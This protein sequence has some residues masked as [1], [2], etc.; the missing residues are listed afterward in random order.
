[1]KIAVFGGTGQTGRQFVEQALEA[2]HTLKVLARNPQK[3]SINHPH[4]EVIEG[5][6]TVLDDV[7]KV[8]DGQ[9]VVV[10]TIGGDGLDDAT[11]RTLG[12]GHII[13]S[14][15][16]S[17]VHQLIVCS[18]LGIGGSKKHLGMMG[19]AVL[20]TLLKK[21]KMDHEG[22]ESLVQSSDLKWVIIRPPRLNDGQHTG[23]YKI[24]HEDESGFKGTQIS[25]A[26]VAHCLLR[27][28]SEPE[29]VGKALSISY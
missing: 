15:K 6:V 16:T 2:G 14:M 19:K 1:M 28:L 3:M 7:Q 13:S 4:L 21:P 11:T 17:D 23:T 24:V 12:T 8:I 25:R 10:C 20:N 29:W 27:A 9:E 18:V 26:D 5:D 22:Q